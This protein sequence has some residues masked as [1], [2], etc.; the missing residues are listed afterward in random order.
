LNV[1]SSMHLLYSLYFAPFTHGFGGLFDYLFGSG[2]GTNIGASLI[3]GF[4]A[5][6]IGY[7]I[8]KRVRRAWA[9]LHTRIDEL[10]ARHDEHRLH[11]NHISQ[12]LDELHDKF[13]SQV[14]D[15]DTSSAKLEKVDVGHRDSES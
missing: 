4:A 2:I 10:H 5:G 15:G 14:L 13:D 7:F 12:R 6:F 3:W 1:R 9:H 11:L 8:A